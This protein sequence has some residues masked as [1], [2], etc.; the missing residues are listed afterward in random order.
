MIKVICGLA[1]N[2]RN[3]LPGMD[4]SAPGYSL[5][6]PHGAEP[7]TSVEEIR[8]GESKLGAIHPSDEAK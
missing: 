1:I 6:K 7:A 3:R 2:I 8:V 5:T 4:I